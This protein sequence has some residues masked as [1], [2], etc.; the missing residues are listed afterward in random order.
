[1][2]SI[3]RSY[4]VLVIPLL[5]AAGLSG[6]LLLGAGAAAV[7]GCA[8]LDEDQDDRVTQ[9]EFSA[10]IYNAWDVND[11]DMLTEAEFDAGVDRSD[12]YA[13]WSG[14]FDAWDTNDDD[15]L[16]EAEFAAGI[17]DEGG[18]REWADRQC[19]ELGL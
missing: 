2:Q 16:T 8:L 13:D 12:V 4:A 10:G 7:G 17:R 1:M 15:S 18:T 3:F 6:C 9:A 19:D 5:L 14:D 11:D